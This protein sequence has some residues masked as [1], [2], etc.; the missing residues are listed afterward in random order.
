MTWTT[1]LYHN[2]VRNGS[3]EL[4]PILR[5]PELDA[6]ANAKDFASNKAYEPFFKLYTTARDENIL[7]EKQA[8][9]NNT[10]VLM[11]TARFKATGG[12]QICA[13]GLGD[14]IEGLDEMIPV[15]VGLLILLRARRMP[16]KTPD[17]QL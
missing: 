3:F 17:D 8:W 13:R 4:L 12:L 1:K 6:I 7:E 14:I 9:E 16:L 11:R 5:L 10:D 15:P 2:P